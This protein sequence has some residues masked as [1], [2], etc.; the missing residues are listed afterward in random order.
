MDSDARLNAQRAADAA[1]RRRREAL[2]AAQDAEYASALAADQAADEV[3]PEKSRANKAPARSATPHPDA[4]REL[5]KQLGDEARALTTTSG[6]SVEAKAPVRTLSANTK[7]AKQQAARADAEARQAAEQAKAAAAAAEA[8]A[9]AAKAAEAVPVT[10]SVPKAHK[11]WFSAL[12]LEK[13]QKTRSGDIPVI[14]VI[15]ETGVGKSTAINR[16]ASSI[17]QKRTVVMKEGGGAEAGTLKTEAQLLPWLGEERHPVIF[18]DMPGL[19]DPEGKDSAIIRDGCKFLSSAPFPGVH[20]IVL[21]VDGQNPR[22]SRSMRE[23]IRVLRD[24]FDSDGKQ[25]FVEYLSVMFTKIPFSEWRDEDKEDFYAEFNS[26]K[27]A[28]ADSWAS[29]TTGLGQKGVLD[30]TQPEAEALKKRFLFVNNA[31]PPKLLTRLNSDFDLQPELGVD[32]I[33]LRA[34]RFKSKPFALSA[35]NPEVMR[36]GE[37]SRKKAEEAKEKAEAARKEAEAARK[38]A[39]ADKEAA[40]AAAKKEADEKARIVKAMGDMQQWVNEIRDATSAL[41]T[42]GPFDEEELNKELTE[43]F[44]KHFKQLHELSQGL[45][46]GALD[47]FKNQL[48][49]LWKAEEDRNLEA[50]RR[51]NEA[52]KDQI[53]AQ[54]DADARR[55]AQ[56]CAR[57]DADVHQIYSEWYNEHSVYADYGGSAYVG[58]FVDRKRGVMESTYAPYEELQTAVAQRLSQLRNRI[59]GADWIARQVRESKWKA[60]TRRCPRCRIAWTRETGCEHVRCGFSAWTTGEAT[61]P[62]PQRGANRLRH[63]CGTAFDFN[64]AAPVTDQEMARFYEKTPQTIEAEELALREQSRHQTFAGPSS[65]SI[66]GAVSY[67]YRGAASAVDRLWNGYRTQAQPP[68][69]MAG[70]PAWR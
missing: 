19:N 4:R 50:S 11:Q 22:L 68:S 23:I 35:M 47:I 6:K 40:E 62:V 61:I 70:R 37:A 13:Q 30:L 17:P 33:Y 26:K 60:C 1:E 28:L 49:S 55:V 42:R 65:S 43:I 41:I 39:E 24:V 64:S 32:D 57:D 38:K 31:L 56:A 46:E 59:F 10:I 34:Q 12:P 14:V 66:G 27:T 16:M 18:V 51:H 9:A 44:E 29:L 15:G 67:V 3:T 20:Q 36:P 8:A 69:S 21:V 52:I 58:R 25:G 63:G 53:L 48:K 7:A 5:T 45:K 2:I 54:F